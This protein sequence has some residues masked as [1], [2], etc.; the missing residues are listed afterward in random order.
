MKRIVI[1]GSA[2]SGKTTLALALASRLQLPLTHL[3]RH[4]WLPGWKEKDNLQFLSEIETIA[5]RESWI[6]EGNYSQTLPMCLKRADFFIYLRP[7]RIRCVLRVIKRHL[8]HRGK[9]RE[10]LAPGCPEG[11]SLSYLQWV[12]NFDKKSG[13]KLQG[14]FDAFKRRKQE[15]AS[16]TD[17]RIFLGKVDERKTS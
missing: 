9:E 8:K 17:V 12:W 2:G 10:D 11:I 15:L 13:P 6:I 7:N 1:I 16:P 4:F 3:D 5:E 14:H